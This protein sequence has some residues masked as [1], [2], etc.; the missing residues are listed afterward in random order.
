MARDKEGTPMKV[1]FQFDMSGF[2]E[3]AR[4]ESF[5]EG[6]PVV[7]LH[8]N[9]SH[10]HVATIEPYDVNGI[11]DPHI[12]V[13]QASFQYGFEENDHKIAYAQAL[14]S[15]IQTAMRR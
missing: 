15:A 10:F 9:S 7:V 1:G 11:I 6:S 14:N 8:N 13:L 4:L 3:S 5:E 12:G 2:H